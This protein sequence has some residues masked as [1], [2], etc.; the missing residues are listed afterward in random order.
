MVLMVQF[1][2]VKNTDKLNITFDMARPL[3][4]DRTKVD[5]KIANLAI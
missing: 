2:S 4:K 5:F 1:I 3:T